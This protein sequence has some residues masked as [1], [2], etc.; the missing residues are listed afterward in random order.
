MSYL[1]ADK[2]GEVATR[3]FG[4]NED[5]QEKDLLFEAA[6]NFSELKAIRKKVRKNTGDKRKVEADV[7]DI[8]QLCYEDDRMLRFRTLQPLI[9]MPFLMFLWRRWTAVW[10][11]IKYT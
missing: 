5:E 9:S 8:L 2:L 4:D 3:G 10:C 7:E 11:L 1:P 6:S